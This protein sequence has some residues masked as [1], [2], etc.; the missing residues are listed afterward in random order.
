[1]LGHLTLSQRSL[2]L[3]SFLLILFS[4]LF[5]LFLPFYLLFTNAIFCLHFSTVGSLQSVFDLIY[6]IIQYIL[7]LFLFLLGPCY[8]FLASSQSLSPGYLS[9]TPF[10]FQDFGSFSLSIFGILYQVDSLYLPLLLSLVG[11]YPVPL[12]AGHFSA[13]SSCLY[14]CVRGAFPYSGSLWFLLIVKVLHCMWSW[15]RGL[16]RFPGYC[17][18]VGGAGFLLAGVQ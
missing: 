3:S 5:H 9:V 4:S 17:V 15:T 13:F 18:L 7:T 12:P 2:R 10:Y 14:C 16:S 1:M 6:C 11:I 8:T